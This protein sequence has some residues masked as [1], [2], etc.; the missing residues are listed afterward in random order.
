ML[1][2]NLPDF[3]SIF[4]QTL[5][6]CMTCESGTASVGGTSFST[7]RW[8]EL[9]SA[10]LLEAGTRSLKH[11]GGV[12]PVEGRACHGD[13]RAEGQGGRGEVRHQGQLRMGQQLA[14]SAPRSR[15]GGVD[16]RD[17]LPRIRR[18]R[19]VAV[20]GYRVV[21]EWHRGCRRRGAT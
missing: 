8:R 7:P 1:S 10:V 11:K 20:S 16:P 14:G 12:R 6:F 18:R 9:S 5:P 13:E 3:Q 4:T 2:G 15:T 17:G 19:R 21:P